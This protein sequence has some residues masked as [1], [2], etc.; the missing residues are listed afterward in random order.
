MIAIL[1]IKPKYVE[2]I[3]NGNKKYEFRKRAFKK[4]VDSILVYATKPVGKIVCMLTVGDI[5]EDK[6][7]ILWEKFN[8]FSG[9]EKKEFF[10]YFESQEKGTAI[11]IKSVNKFPEPLNPYDLIPNFVAPQSWYYLPTEQLNNIKRHP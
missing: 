8:K 9:L 4:D 3:L 2:N 10:M 11:E 5:V 1:P 7:E 6:P